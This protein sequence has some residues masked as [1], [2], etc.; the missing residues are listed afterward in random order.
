MKSDDLSETAVKLLKSVHLDVEL[1]TG[2]SLHKESEACQR[3]VQTRGIP[4]AIKWLEDKLEWSLS[5]KGARS[6]KPKAY[7]C[8]HFA[9]FDESSPIWLSVAAFAGARQIS[10]ILRKTCDISCSETEQEAIQGWKDRNASLQKPLSKHQ[11]VLADELSKELYLLFPDL[12][13]DTILIPTAGPGVTAEKRDHLDR[14]EFY[15]FSWAKFAQATYELPGGSC[16]RAVP[17]TWKKRRLIFVEPSSRMLAQKALQGWMYQQAQSSP[18][19]H[20]VNFDDQEVQ[21]RKLLQIGVSSIDLSDASDYIDRRLVWA[22]FKRLPNLRARL[23]EARSARTDDDVLI[24]M[25]GTMGNATTFP[26]MTFLLAA[27]VS[28]AEKVGDH[29]VKRARHARL[30]NNCWRRAGVFGDDIVV[31][32]VL[33]GTVV[34]LL[35]DLGL[36]VNVDKSYCDSDFKESCGLD[37][38]K[39][40]PVTPVR[41]KSLLALTFEDRDRL[42]SYSN[43]LLL[44]GCWKT[45]DFLLSLAKSIF[46]VSV[47]RPHQPDVAYSFSTTYLQGGEWHNDWQEWIPRKPR[48]RQAK[49]RWRDSPAHLDYYLANQARLT[50]DRKV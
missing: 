36:R 30:T 31:D 41:V 48:I 49:R 20:Y 34:S 12:D 45:A 8:L 2:L 32:D 35:V 9:A 27:V 28:L 13:K 11:L 23:F 50:S 47:D 5:P 3:V 26:V 21:R 22:A 46:P 7:A 33:Y 39:G 16:P 43:D 19:S 17:K 14:P 4:A 38:Y 29:V 24:R 25:F 40:Q 1:M 37:L 10:S 44:V 6:R 18:I 15:S 42:L